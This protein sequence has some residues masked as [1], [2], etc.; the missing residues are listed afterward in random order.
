MPVVDVAASAFN[1]SALCAFLDEGLPA[2]ARDGRVEAFVLLTLG[3]AAFGSPFH[4]A[5]LRRGRR[6]GRFSFWKSRSDAAAATWTLPRRRGRGGDVDLP[7]RR[8]R[9]GDV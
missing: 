6:A 1:A 7:R 2:L 8:G 4:P 3:S 9:G 5:T